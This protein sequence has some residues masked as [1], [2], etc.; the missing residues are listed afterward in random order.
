MASTDA[1]TQPHVSWDDNIDLA[2][3]INERRRQINFFG[4]RPHVRV[5]KVIPDGWPTSR[6]DLPRITKL[7]REA[8]QNMI[9]RLEIVAAM[10]LS[11]GLPASSSSD[12]ARLRYFE[13]KVENKLEGLGKVFKAACEHD[14]IAAMFETRVL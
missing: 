14:Q 12:A 11:M 2:N 10:K 6:W 9:K 7:R 4:M 3:A 13:Q 8:R 5:F 1:C